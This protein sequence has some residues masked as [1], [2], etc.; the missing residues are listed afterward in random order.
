MSSKAP[1]RE[2][3]AR[4]RFRLIRLDHGAWVAEW[5]RCVG[6]RPQSWVGVDDADADAGRAP[7]P[8]IRR[9]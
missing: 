7:T 5:G 4:R 1:C 6:A 9:V 2:F 8:R 3:A